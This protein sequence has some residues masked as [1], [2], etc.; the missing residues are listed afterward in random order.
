MRPVLQADKKTVC[1][2]ADIFLYNRY[3]FG[4][5]TKKIFVPFA[6]FKITV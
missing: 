3:I 1:F 2:S 6:L 5:K 4:P